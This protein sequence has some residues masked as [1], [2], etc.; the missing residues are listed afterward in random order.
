MA[1]KP[2]SA[3]AE[4]VQVIGVVTLDATVN[5]LV[6][7]RA[8]MLLSPATLPV[9]FDHVC[10]A[11]RANVNGAYVLGD[12]DVGPIVR[13]VELPLAGFV[14]LVQAMASTVKPSLPRV[15]VVGSLEVS[16]VSDVAVPMLLMYRP[17]I[18]GE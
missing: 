10:D 8:R 9:R 12:T 7:V 2:L 16:V 3:G 11:E 6:T 17:R 4:S 13:A 5:G 18:A 1:A 15:I 14:P